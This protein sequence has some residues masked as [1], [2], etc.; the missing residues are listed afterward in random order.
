[1][2]LSRRREMIMESMRLAIRYPSRTSKSTLRILTQA[3]SGIFKEIYT[4]K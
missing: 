2:M 4:Q 3:K 1:M